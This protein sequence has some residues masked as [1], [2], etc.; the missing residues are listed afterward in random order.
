MFSNLKP[1]VALAGRFFEALEFIQLA[2]NSNWFGLGCPYH[3]GT[4]TL[5]SLFCAFILGLA[6][7]FL[8]CALLGIAVFRLLALPLDFGS[9]APAQ[10]RPRALSLA[11]L[12]GYVL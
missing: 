12:Q 3:C 10:H 9:A 5:P 8:S 4:S 1:M 7:G 11:R 2:V 6:C